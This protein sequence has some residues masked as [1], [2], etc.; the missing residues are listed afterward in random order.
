MNTA[1]MKILFDFIPADDPQLVDD[2]WTLK[3]NPNITIQV[4]GYAGGYAV[5]EF[6]PDEGLMT[7]HGVFK[8]LK[9]AVAKALAV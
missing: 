3:A 9:A 6:N 5:N 2:E 1:A 8:T 7:D 4:C